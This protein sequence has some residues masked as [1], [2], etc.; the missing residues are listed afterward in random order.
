M[1]ENLSGGLL[2]GGIMSGGY[3]PFPDMPHSG[4][5][6]ASVIAA[7]FN[8]GDCLTVRRETTAVCQYFVAAQLNKPC[9]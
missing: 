3:C 6:V 5:Q 9:R 2:S 7:L 4:M 1:G 8:D